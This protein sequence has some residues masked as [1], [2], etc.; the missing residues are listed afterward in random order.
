MESVLRNNELLEQAS[1]NKICVL[2]SNASYNVSLYDSLCGYH[3]KNLL[4]T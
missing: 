2:C 3:R 1:E 4:W